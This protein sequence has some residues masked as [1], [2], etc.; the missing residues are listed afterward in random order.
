MTTG[1]PQRTTGPAGPTRSAWLQRFVPGSLRAR[2][3]L[4]ITAAMVL[5]WALWLACQV[6][7]M[8]RQQ[9]GRWDASMQA[10]AQQILLSMP[11]GLGAMDQRPGYALPAAVK[12]QAE[13][14]SYQV[15]LSDGRLALRSSDAP[16]T[17]WVPLDFA[18]A[19]NFAHAQVDGAGWRVHTVSD[20]Q[21]RL[22]VQVA[23]SQHRLDAD[24]AQR[25]NAGLLTTLAQ[26]LVLSVLVWLIVRWSLAP[27]QKVR[28]VLAQRAA[29]D[30]QP[31]PAAGLPGEMQPLIDAFNRLLQRLDTALQAER[32]FVAD[33]A[34]ELRTPLAALMAQARLAQSAPTLEQN[35]AALQQLVEGIERSARLTEQLLDMARVDA[36]VAAP[37]QP[38]VAL[39]EIAAMV[40]HEFGSAAR[41][42]R[43]QLRLTTEPCHTSVA[44]DAVG[45]L[46]RNLIDNAIRHG[47]EGVTVEV[48]AGPAAAPAQPEAAPPRPAAAGAPEAPAALLQVRDSGPGVPAHERSRIFARFYRVPGSRGRGSG[49]GLSLVARIA[50]LHGARVTVGDGIGGRGLSVSVLL[51]GT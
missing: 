28:E 22:Q 7:Q 24:L 13:A 21:G 9:S 10:I 49:I 30:L 27:A 35:Q 18:R 42:A 50:E 41:A 5:F 51:P 39:H 23:K 1:P 4:G 47:G 43:V 26:M 2:L 20:A 36:V 16:A 31:L 46:L 17:P 19:E 15:W 29:L 25:L 6:Q 44:V 33:A 32:R 14:L 3:L 12:P 11:A 37:V 48:H 8:S 45:V 40:T 34:H 38:A